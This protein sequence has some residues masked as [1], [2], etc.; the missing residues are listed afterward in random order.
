MDARHNQSGMTID[1]RGFER[2]GLTSVKHD[3]IAGIFQAL[4]FGID[5]L[6]IPEKFFHI[7][8]RRLDVVIPVD[9]H[10]VPAVGAGIYGF[11]AGRHGLVD[12]VIAALFAF[13]PMKNGINFLFDDHD[14]SLPL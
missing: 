9:L 8:E 14:A 7:L 13:L 10:S 2:A 1:T 12:S 5:F 6:Q 11:F 4:Q 3:V